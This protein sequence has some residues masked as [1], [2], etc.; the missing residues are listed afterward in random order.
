MEYI[1]MFISHIFKTA[2]YFAVEGFPEITPDMLLVSI[3]ALIYDFGK[4]ASMYLSL[5]FI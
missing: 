1:I 3:Q 2:E 5:L 4:I